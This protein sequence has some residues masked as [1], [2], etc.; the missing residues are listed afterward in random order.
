M[1]VRKIEPA[2]ED[3]RG[4][5]ADIFYKHPLNHVGVV[6]SNPGAIRGNHYHKETTQHMYIMKGSLR[7]Y[8]QML[9]N[10][11]SPVKSI[12]INE[13]ELVTTP[14]LEVHAIEILESNIFIVFSE[15]LRGGKDYE[16]DTF[17][18]STSLISKMSKRSKY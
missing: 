7:Y 10:D 16:K 13:G 12:V 6:H 14:P 4:S 2:F 18:V 3:E 17:R 5:I 1:I 8:Y 15:G 11:Q 9:N